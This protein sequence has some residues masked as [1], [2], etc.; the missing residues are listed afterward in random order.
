MSLHGVCSGDPPLQE[1]APP[2][3]L[4][5]SEP[6]AAKGAQSAGKNAFV[7]LD[8]RSSRMSGQDNQQKNGAEDV[9]KE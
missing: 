3:R 8:R 6:F 1:E 4:V 9:K 7:K 5:F 2:I